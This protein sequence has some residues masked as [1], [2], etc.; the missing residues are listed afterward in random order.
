MRI[1][2]HRLLFD[3]QNQIGAGE[4]TFSA[5]GGL[6]FQLLEPLCFDKEMAMYKIGD[7]SKLSQIPVK[8]LRSQDRARS[9]PASSARRVR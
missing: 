2:L 9:A 4:Y 6:T 8:T 1:E 7:F 5:T 3:E